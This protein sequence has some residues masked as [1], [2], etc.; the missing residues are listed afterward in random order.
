MMPG[1]KDEDHQ[2]FVDFPTP[3]GNLRP[4]QLCER[5]IVE[6]HCPEKSNEKDGIGSIIK[7]SEITAKFNISLRSPFWAA[8]GRLLHTDKLLENPRLRDLGGGLDGGGQA[9]AS[10]RA[11]FEV[12][13][14]SNET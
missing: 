12:G 13:L 9:L 10:R 1:V 8:R 3:P 5:M 14:L 7:G 11:R 2:Q 6:S 4:P